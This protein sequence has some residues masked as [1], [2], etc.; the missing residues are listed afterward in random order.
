MSDL[1]YL[2]VLYVEDDEATREAFTRF[3]KQRAGKLFSAASGEEGLQK[4]HE[5]RPNLLIIDLIMP[6]MSGLDMI[7]EIRKTDKDCRILITSTVSELSTVLEAVDLGIDHYIIKPIDT[8]DLVAKM[9]GIAQMIRSR[10]DKDRSIDLAR[11]KNSGVAEDTIRREFL[12][13]MKTCSGKGPQDVKVLFFEN[14]VEITAFDTVTT[15]EKII[16]ANR[17]NVSMVE[18]FRRLFYEEISQKLEECVKQATGYRAKVTSLQ[19]DGTKRVD[20]IIL[21][22]IENI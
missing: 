1:D 20:K 22:V 11:L 6:G 3:L 21:T 12:K 10:E 14:K 16:A 8:E 13:L 18:Q 4:F 15:M 17:K 19:V 2:R 9:A 5:L 7:G